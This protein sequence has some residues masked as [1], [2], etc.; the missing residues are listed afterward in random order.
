[1]TTADLSA[2]RAVASRVHPDYPEDDAVFSERL[3]LY[4]AGCWVLDRRETGD[5]RIGED[6]TGGITGYII[7]H[8]WRH[9]DAPP[10]N[11]LLGALPDAPTTYYIHDIAL[12]PEARGTGAAAAILAT[13]LGRA[14]SAHLGTLSL[15]AV[16]NSTAFWR[17]HGFEVVTTPILDE[18][19]KS[20]D[21]DARF[22]VRPLSDNRGA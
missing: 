6:R 1:M 16:N 7:S 11:T 12:L 3:R 9:G 22:M 18:K 10:L 13:L 17:R 19:L 2:V 20:Y 4:A 5:S 21:R 14:R 15:V 8:P